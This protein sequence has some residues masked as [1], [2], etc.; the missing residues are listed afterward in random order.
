MKVKKE[1]NVQDPHTGCPQGKGQRVK[2]SEER[3]ILAVM[4][5]VEPAKEERCRKKPE[6]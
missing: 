6:R 4:S 5:A 1:T 2:S 3:Q